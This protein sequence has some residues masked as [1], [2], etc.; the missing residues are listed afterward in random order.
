M[1]DWFNN[2]SSVYCIVY[3]PPQVKSPSTII[4]PSFMGSYLPLLPLPSENHILL[5]LY[6]VF[7][8][9]FYF[10][11]IPSPFSPR[12][13]SPPHLTAVS[14]FS[15]CMYIWTFIDLSMLNIKSTLELYFWFQDI[16][17]YIWMNQK[18]SQEMWKYWAMGANFQFINK[19]W[20]SNIQDGD[21]S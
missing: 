19:F 8:I 13:P 10:C 5:S 9:L 16:H 18:R 1:I 20:W 3:S 21:Y 4:Y 12:P 11:L 6:E 17:T 7:L 15:V 2:K 14:L